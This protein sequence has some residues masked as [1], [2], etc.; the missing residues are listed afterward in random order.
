M[1]A[2]GNGV[3]VIVKETG[4]PGQPLAVGVTVIVAVTGIGPVFVATKGEMFPV[5][6]AARPIEVLLFVQLNT[7]PPTVPEKFTAFVEEP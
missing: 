6:F 3:T 4:T 5:P 7:V 2:V 1:L